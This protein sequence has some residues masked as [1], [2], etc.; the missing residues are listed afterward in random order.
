MRAQAAA[1]TVATVIGAPTIAITIAN[2]L[3]VEPAFASLH[4]DPRFESIVKRAGL[5]L[6]SKPP[7]GMQ[8]GSEILQRVVERAPTYEPA[9][10]ELATAMTLLSN[11]GAIEPR[12][13]KPRADE[14]ARQALELDPTDPAPHAILGH[15]AMFFTYD[16]SAS[17]RH[18]DRAIT[19]G[20]SHSASVGWSSFYWSSLGRH[21]EAIAASRKAVSLDPLNL[22]IRLIDLLSHHFARRYQD[23]VA[24]SEQMADIDAN[25][26]EAYRLRSYALM[27]LGRL[28]EAHRA[29]ETAVRLSGGH[30]YHLFH[31][32]LTHLAAGRRAEAESIAGQF[33][34]APQSESIYF[35]LVCNLNGPLGNHDRAFAALEKYFEHLGHWMAMLECDPLY[36]P[37]RADPRFDE[38]AR[39]VGIPEWESPALSASP[40]VSPKPASV[41]KPSIAVMPF[42]NLSPDPDDEYFADGLADEIITDLSSI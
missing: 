8:R 23:V 35:V 30:P 10:A 37:L 3:A 33:D 34:D 16:W 9:L 19:L 14:L 42:A 27:R 5:H 38:L 24:L 25:F 7:D 18:F 2:M 11:F 12:A 15:N 13:G 32:A 17:R 22:L 31:A 1:T 39:R 41:G 4:G 29:A 21:T 36:D 6:L 28:D 20:P 26:S 40:A